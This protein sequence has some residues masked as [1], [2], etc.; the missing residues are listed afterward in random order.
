VSVV[1]MLEA[2]TNLSRLVEAVESGAETEIVIA[3]NGRPAARLVAVR[4]P[5]TG[6]RLGVA[7]GAFTLPDTIDAHNATVEALFTGRL[8]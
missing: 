3:R 5:N 7:K 8:E 6:R 1:N 2:K 4:R